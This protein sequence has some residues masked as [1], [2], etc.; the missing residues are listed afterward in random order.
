MVNGKQCTICWHV[1]DNKISHE[2]PEVVDE[3]I[4]IIRTRVKDV[5]VKRG[6][7]HTFVGIDFEINMDG[8][9]SLDMVDYLK[10]SIMTLGEPITKNVPTPV[11]SDLC[12]VKES[13]ILDENSSEIFHHIVAK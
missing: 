4:E 12:T 7:K 1:D 13:A 3:V 10:E 5:T 6:N 9:V 11:S 8:T 2:D